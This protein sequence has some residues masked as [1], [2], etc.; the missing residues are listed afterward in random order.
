M[1]HLYL[2]TAIFINNRQR[3]V[4]EMKPDSIAIFNSNDEMPSNGDALYRYVPNSDLYWL[5][6]IEQEDTM[7]MLFPGNPDE[8]Y[9]EVLGFGSAK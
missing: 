5:T 4:K 8:K 1:K 6:G 2:I 9:R 3:F 7:L